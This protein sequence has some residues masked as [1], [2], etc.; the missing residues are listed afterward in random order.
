MIG[1]HS[2]D[3]NFGEYLP[4]VPPRHF[5]DCEPRHNRFYDLED[6]LFQKETV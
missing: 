5:W 1:H 6:D 2:P 4:F 3:H